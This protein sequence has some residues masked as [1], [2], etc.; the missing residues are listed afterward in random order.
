MKKSFSSFFSG[1]RS[2]VILSL[3]LFF[4]PS[5]CI[6]NFNLSSIKDYSIFSSGPT[7][8]VTAAPTSTITGGAYS[9]LNSSIS[10]YNPTNNPLELYIDPPDGFSSSTALGVFMRCISSKGDSA[11]TKV[12]YTIDGD[13]PTRVSSYTTYE[14]PYVHIDTPFRVGRS[15]VFQAICTERSIDGNTYRSEL[16]TRHYT[17][18]GASRPQRYRHPVPFFPDHSS[19]PLLFF[20]ATVSSSLG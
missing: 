6:R 15:R 7:T 17:V 8:V 5:H 13:E 16:I 3:C 4:Q 20:S 1:R 2:F 14:F 10:V 12:Y 18:E 9:W 19:S 11:N